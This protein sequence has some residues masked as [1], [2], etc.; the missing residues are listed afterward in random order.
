[1]FKVFLCYRTSDAGYAAPHIYHELAEVFGEGNVFEYTDAMPAGVDF[2]Q[3]VV[4]QLRQMQ[5]FLP[6]I[7]AQWADCRDDNGELR[8]HQPD[9]PVRIELETALQTE[10]LRI[11]PIFLNGIACP[12]KTKLP[13]SIAPLFDRSAIH[14][15]LK[16][17]EMR[18][19]VN[20]L[21]E[22]IRT[23]G[24]RPQPDP[25]PEIKRLKNEL[26]RLEAAKQ[27]TE[28]AYA[29][30]RRKWIAACIAMP[31]SVIIL[32]SIAGIENNDAIGVPIIACIVV[33]IIAFRWYRKFNPKKIKAEL[34]IIEKDILNTKSRLIELEKVK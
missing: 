22:E 1:M 3:H 26:L 11:I 17:V 10:K 4:Q 15:G 20:R 33:F 19:G 23:A 32:L 25:N 13:P 29:D 14:I 16:P 31:L 6:L 24:I 34:D 7:G 2:R 5:V 27:E 18:A 12:S 9:D 28:K 21:I 8:L 30:N